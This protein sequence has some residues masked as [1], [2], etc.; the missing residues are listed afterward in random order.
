MMAI[1]SIFYLS[2][3]VARREESAMN[4]VVE[5]TWPVFGNAQCAISL[6]L[7]FIWMSA[8]FAR[9][10]VPYSLRHNIKT[11]VP[12]HQNIAYVDTLIH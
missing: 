9:D 8:S 6:M 11:I 2:I 4:N 7:D 3:I 1:F 12:R 5:V 10:G